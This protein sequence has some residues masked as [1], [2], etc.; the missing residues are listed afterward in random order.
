MFKNRNAKIV[1][2]SSS[3]DV[4]REE[5]KGAHMEEEDEMLDVQEAQE[6]AEQLAAKEAQEAAAALEADKAALARVKARADQAQLA[7]DCELRT[8]NC[9]CE[10]VTARTAR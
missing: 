2:S 6:E 9:S 5:A 3:S 7:S 4:Q 8:A 1:P 10:S